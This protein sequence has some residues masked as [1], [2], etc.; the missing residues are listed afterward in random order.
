MK[1][2]YKGFFMCS[3]KI[4][5][6]ITPYFPKN[7]YSLCFVSLSL[8]EALIHSQVPEFTSCNLHHV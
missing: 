5:F 2:K 8:L 7:S 4:L 6:N 1:W 3:I